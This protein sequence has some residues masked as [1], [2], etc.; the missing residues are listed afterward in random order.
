MATYDTV[1]IGAGLTGL[2]AAR[3]LQAAGKSVLILEARDRVGGR[4]FTTELTYNGAPTA[5][6]FGAHFI[7]NE[8]WQSS[9]WD[10]VKELNLEVFEQYEGPED[11][12]P[13]PYWAGEG[14]NLQYYADSDT[15]S[16]YIGGT[17]PNTPAGQFYLGYLDSLT[18]S[19]KLDAP[20]DTDNAEMLDGM[21]VWDWVTSVD[22]PGYGPAPTEFQSLTRMLCRV[23]FSTEPE[24]I[25]MLWLLFYVASSGGLAAFQD[26]RWPTQGAQGYRLKDGAQ[27]IAKAV[28]SQLRATDPNCI[29][30]SAVVTAVTDN[31]ADCTVTY[32]ANGTAATATGTKVLCALAPALTDGLTFSPAIPERAGLGTAMANSHMIMTFVTFTDTFW[33]DD[34]TTYTSGTVNG[35][36]TDNISRY[37]LSGDA[38]L[39]DDDI[40]WIMDNTSAEGQA[41]L[42]AFIV[43]D[44]AK[45]WAPKTK[46]ERQT[47]VVNTMAKMFGP[48]AKS[49][50]LDYYEMDWN[51][52]GFSLGCPA[53][54]FTKGNFLKYAGEVLANQAK[55]HGNIYFASTESA[56]VSNGYMS[57]AVWSGGQV[58]DKLVADL[59]GVTYVP[60]D[61]VARAQSMTFCIKRVMKAV[62][63]QNPFME[64]PIMT[65]DNQFTP[66]GGAA[67]SN[68]A[69]GPFVGLEGTIAF[70]LQLGMY[71]TI[72]TF[73]VDS[74]SVDVGQ[75]VGFARVTVGG[76]AN[77]TGIPFADVTGTMAFLFNDP[78]EGKAL[79]AHDML[80]LDTAMIDQI[81]F[82]PSTPPAKPALAKAPAADASAPALDLS[83][84]AVFA[85][86]NLP[87]GTPFPWVGDSTII[88][89]P[90]GTVAPA[91][92]YFGQAGLDAL[93]ADML[94]AI[95]GSTLIAGTYDP[96]ALSL[97]M[98]Y[99]I[100]GVS[101]VSGTPF[102]QPL[103]A[104]Y[105]ASNGLNQ[106]LQTLRYMTDGVALGA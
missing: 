61:P 1:I 46:A 50:F 22:L 32:T 40:V 31:G 98:L 42:F 41:A 84:E 101:L 43:G 67:L 18:D 11:V 75:N 96:D 48:K 102:K 85:A 74:I 91:G 24:N 45:K 5:F 106:T 39:A 95:T 10:L 81:A 56:L 30:E 87:A 69:G 33:R 44:A 64:I 19:I 103:M 47:L 72:D 93:N 89:G 73:N 90:G 36:P 94:R 92:P 88:W 80:F 97:Y 60:N 55:P 27:S 77:A 57:G 37:G 23:G 35:I 62:Q 29:Q 3:K 54:H 17:I 4:T 70:F 7:G 14:A 86:A 63:M 100:T 58:G 78:S 25:S 59:N 51:N 38:L 15:T 68:P 83:R 66:P 13:P 2:C 12:P 16:A 8:I 20:E 82:P 65:T 9:V 79:V 99:E 53:G 49:E 105:Q 28:A 76:H 26:L 71:F 6:D 21:S 104:V 52:E 34:T